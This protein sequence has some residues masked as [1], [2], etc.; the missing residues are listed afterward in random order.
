MAK[1]FRLQMKLRNNRLIEAREALGLSAPKAADVI[2]VAYGLLIRYEALS[3][4]P[5]S[6]D[7]SDW[8]PSAVKVADFYNN[9]CEHFWPDVVRAV[10]KAS[11]EM[12]VDAGEVA[13]L[14][15][16]APSNPEELLLEKE[17]DVSASLAIQTLS[18][19]ER[20]VLAARANEETYREI[21]R[22]FGVSPS[23]IMQIEGGALSKVRAHM[24][25]ADVTDR[26]L[27]TLAMRVRG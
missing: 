17:R 23:R 20:D 16:E 15:A 6:R 5:W 3:A 21:G 11:V 2:G 14:L 25:H 22:R 10:E 1:E 26:S 12:K 13:L 7:Q 9:T 27:S 4:D 19:R 24:K 8:R 18:P